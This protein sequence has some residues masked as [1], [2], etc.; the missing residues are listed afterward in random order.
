M[1]PRKK[2]TP[3]PG[4]ILNDPVM[5]QC[6][7]SGTVCMGMSIDITRNTVCC[8]SCMSDTDLTFQLDAEPAFSE[9]LPW[10]FIRAIPFPVVA[11]PK[12]S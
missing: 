7:L 2:I 10:C 8:P 11:T 12:E 3:Q 4:V 9:I 6:N 5:D 1:P